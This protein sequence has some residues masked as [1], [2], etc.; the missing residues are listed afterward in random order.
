MVSGFWLAPWELAVALLV[1]VFVFI[2]PAPRAPQARK[3]K[4]GRR[5]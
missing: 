5:R 1:L 2:G 3:G 4:A